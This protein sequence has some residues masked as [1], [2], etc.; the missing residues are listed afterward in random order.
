V[1]L[2]Y[3]IKI[4]PIEATAVF[5][6]ALADIDPAIYRALLDSMSDKQVI[7][8]GKNLSERLLEARDLG[9]ATIV[10]FPIEQQKDTTK[11]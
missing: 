9:R 5:M 10:T 1:K 2:S 3:V 6:G 11:H 4:S 7:S 8:L